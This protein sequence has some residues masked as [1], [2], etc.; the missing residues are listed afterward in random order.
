MIDLKT[1]KHADPEV[2]S[3]ME[4][5]LLRQQNNLELIASENFVSAAV[6]A[7]AGSHLT[8]KYAEGYPSKRYYGGCQ[9]VDEVENIAIERAK[10]LFNCSYAN[11]QPHSGA[12]ANLAAF[13][14]AINVGDTILSMSLS[15]GGHLSHGSPV[16]FSGKN[17]NIIPYGLCEKTERIDYGE[18]ERLALQHKPKM[19]IAGASAYSRVIDFAAFRAIADKV[20][21]VLMA[22]VAHIAGQII[23]GLHP[24]PFPHAHIVTTTTHKT[25][26]GPR[27]GLILADSEEWGAKINKAIFPGLQGGP[28]QHVIA[29]KAIAF[30][31]ALQPEFK[32]YQQQV[33]KNAAAL[34]ASLSKGGLEL[35]SGGTDNHLVLVK[36]LKNNITG[37]DLE[38]LLDEC[39]ITVNKNSIPNDPNSFFVTGGIRVGTP[40]VTTRGMNEDDMK[41]IG[42]FIVR[43]IE[44]RESVLSKVKQEVLALCAKYPLYKGDILI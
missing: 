9:F 36:L 39:N 37:K 42:D 41:L 17:Y 7:A 25:M 8:N 31:E 5:E 6:L 44:G 4:K 34:A 18:V 30:G 20:G 40:S 22:D 43:V 13:V 38:H 14:A 11:V 29:A 3:G 35:V 26:R 33:V 16:N 23:T 24:S 1:I 27:G 12:S 19:I 28:L 2:F 21:A 32:K 10:K 15:S